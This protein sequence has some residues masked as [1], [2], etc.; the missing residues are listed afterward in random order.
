MGLASWLLAEASLAFLRRDGHGMVRAMDAQ[1]RVPSRGITFG[2]WRGHVEVGGDQISVVANE[3]PNRQD[4]D[5]S[6]VMRCSFNSRNGLWAFRMKDG[7]KHYLQASGQILSADRSPAGR[8]ANEWIHELMIAH[9][10][11]IYSA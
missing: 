8:A 6:Q 11:L 5:P 2:G 7:T 3:G 10:V 4:I 1:V 9:D